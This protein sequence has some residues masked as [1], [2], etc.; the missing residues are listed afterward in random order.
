MVTRKHNEFLETGLSEE[1]EEE[2]DDLGYDSEAEE[3]SKGSRLTGLPSRNAKRRKLDSDVEENDEKAE[4]LGDDAAALVS[5]EEDRQATVP[6]QED[7]NDEK[8]DN[9]KTSTQSQRKRKSKLTTLQVL[10][11]TQLARTQRAAKKTGVIYLSRIPP[12]MKPHRVKHFLSPFGPIGRIFLSPEAPQSHTKRVKSGGNKKR[13]FTD[14]WVEF[15][16]K[17]DAKIVAETLNTQIV[18]GKKGGWYHDDVWNIKYLK[19]FKWAHLT[20]QIANENAE[21]AARLRADIGR[22]RRE[23]EHFVENVERAKMME[24]M[25]AKRKIKRE[26]EGG[27][28]G[29]FGVGRVGEDVEGQRV[30]KKEKKEQKGFVRQFRQNEVKSKSTKGMEQREEVTRVLS[31]IF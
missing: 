29:S 25:E 13:S 4:T 23:N 11:P 10:T 12:F 8:E 14:G 6:R 27:V 19:G 28:G 2:E 1:E 22:V 31:K 18:G 21:R 15:V 26:R 30:E 17:A 3:Q 9:E 16:S 5:E 7:Q 24:G 20:E